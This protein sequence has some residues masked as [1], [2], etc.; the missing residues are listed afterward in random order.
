MIKTFSF[1]Q[2]VI[3]LSTSILIF[4][5]SKHF[6]SIL[7][8]DLHAIL[9]VLSEDRLYAS[10]DKLYSILY[11]R[12]N[13]IRLANWSSDLTE[14]FDL[15]TLR[16]CT[17]KTKLGVMYCLMPRIQC[18]ICQRLHNSSSDFLIIYRAEGEVNKKK[19]RELLWRLCQKI[20]R[21]Q[22]VKRYISQ[23]KII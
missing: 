5:S 7:S 17:I 20:H 15:F 13:Y 2:N 23:K 12:T 21:I 8:I 22:G 6:H 14:T 19:L 3:K 9:H 10:E 4:I 11:R 16:L 1:H 18:I